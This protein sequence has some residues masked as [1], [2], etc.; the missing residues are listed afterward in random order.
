M[1]TLT[2]FKTFLKDKG[3]G[4]VAK[5]SKFA[6]GKIRNAMDLSRDVVIV[7]YGPGDGVITRVLLEEMTP[8]SRLIALE[9]NRAFVSLLNA[10]GDPRLIVINDRAENLPNVLKE[11]GVE[12]V[13]YIFSG[14]P[15]SFLKKQERAQVV[16]N[17]RSALVER[18]KFIVYQYSPLMAKYMKREF[19]NIRIGF[20]PFNLPSYFLM[21][22]VRSANNRIEA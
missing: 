6:V 20:I 9:T 10:V 4:A 21:E 2:Y 3:I 17:T 19:G 12:R 8:S 5:S 1:P 22:S 14:I 11:L 18:G 15:F 13:D 16:R 7:E